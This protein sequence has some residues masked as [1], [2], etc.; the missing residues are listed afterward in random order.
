M[1]YRAHT[2]SILYRQ[3]QYGPAIPGPHRS[4]SMVAEV[5]DLPQ[6]HT[7]AILLTD[8][9]R[10]WH[11]VC[12]SLCKSFTPIPFFSVS[13]RL[14]VGFLTN[15]Q[16]RHVFWFRRLLRCCLGNRGY[17]AGL[18]GKHW[19][20]Q[21]FKRMKLSSVMKTSHHWGSL[22]GSYWYQLIGSR[23]QEPVS[24]HRFKPW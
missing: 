8:M 17:A 2:V 15:Q 9:G 19:K 3:V 20:R 24:I 4:G 18:C 16:H 12:F 1:S 6:S 22:P 7:F 11:G 5:W 21:P 23:W 10:K 13:G 14:W